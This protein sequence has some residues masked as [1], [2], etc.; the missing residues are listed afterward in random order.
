MLKHL[1]WHPV[2]AAAPAEHKEAASDILQGRAQRSLLHALYAQRPPT[3]P[4]RPT[5]C[6][7]GGGE[8]AADAVLRASGAGHQES[9]PAGLANAPLWAPLGAGS[10]YPM[11]LAPPADLAAPADPAA[12]PVR[13]S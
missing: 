3:P 2:H 1:A 7:P 5:T 10:P 11:A 9:I 13:D 6:G 4:R 12:M 8:E